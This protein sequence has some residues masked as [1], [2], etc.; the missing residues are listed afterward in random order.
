LDGQDHR[1]E[2]EGER[3]WKR[4]ATEARKD[5]LSVLRRMEGALEAAKR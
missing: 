5:A 1:F 2:V 4:Q 3:R